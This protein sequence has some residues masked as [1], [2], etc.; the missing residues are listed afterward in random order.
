MVISRIGF[1][2]FWIGMAVEGVPKLN[3]AW[4]TTGIGEWLAKATAPGHPYPW[5]VAFLNEV[6]IPNQSLFAGLV[7]IG[8]LATGLCL[9]LG[10]FV[11][12][13]AWVGFFMN[14]NFWLAFNWFEEGLLP[15]PALYYI[16]AAAM[17]WY[18]LARAGRRIGL[19]AWLARRWPGSWLW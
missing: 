6:V 19:D 18:A 17:V 3:A 12:P 2:L 8:E 16:T 13:A 4:F 14:L 1:G 7:L 9:V 10:L 5:Y 15:W 11:P